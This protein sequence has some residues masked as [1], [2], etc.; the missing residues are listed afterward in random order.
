MI[1]HREAGAGCEA[2]DAGRAALDVPP[3]LSSYVMPG[4][5]GAS[6]RRD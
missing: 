1:G 2:Y 5:I 4:T 3:G 6:G